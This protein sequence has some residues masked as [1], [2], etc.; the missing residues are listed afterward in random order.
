MYFK[1][2]TFS[3]VFLKILREKLIKINNFSRLFAISLKEG[4]I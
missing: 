4:L 2:F 1:S 3:E